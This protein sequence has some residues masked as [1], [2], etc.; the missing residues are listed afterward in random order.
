MEFM[1]AR[2]QVECPGHQWEPT[3]AAFILGFY[4]GISTINENLTMNMYKLQRTIL[5]K[6]RLLEI[7]F[8]LTC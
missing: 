2:K 6:L 3:S 1:L 5:S 8:M 4:L 7:D